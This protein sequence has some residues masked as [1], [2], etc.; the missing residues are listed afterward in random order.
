MIKVCKQE[1][2][3]MMF[4]SNNSQSPHH[5]Q[6][7]ITV[8]MSVCMHACIEKKN[9]QTHWHLQFL[10]RFLPLTNAKITP[11]F[12]EVWIILTHSWTLSFPPTGHANLSSWRRRAEGA[13]ER[14]GAAA[15]EGA[16]LASLWRE[17]N[18]FS[19][20]TA[21]AASEGWNASQNT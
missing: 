7:N 6:I 9:R 1:I 18:I 8:Y 2:S 3:T 17:A 11:S 5:K 16:D 21:F 20:S 13:G 14:A 15:G 4:H 12:F 10:L 19:A